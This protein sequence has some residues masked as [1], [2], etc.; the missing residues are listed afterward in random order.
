MLCKNATKLQT[1]DGVSS[2]VT[3]EH[4]EHWLRSRAVHKVQLDADRVR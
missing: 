3:V 1:N 4:L 2:D